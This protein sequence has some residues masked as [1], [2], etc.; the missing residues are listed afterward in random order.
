MTIQD[1]CD[2]LIENYNRILPGNHFEHSGLLAA[3][4]AM[5]LANGL[6]VDPEKLRECKRMI[7]KQKGL[8]SN[9]RGT[10]EFIVRCKMA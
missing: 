7:R 5:Y 1:K 3:G 6:K 9:F 4:A 2:Q 10:A 8:F